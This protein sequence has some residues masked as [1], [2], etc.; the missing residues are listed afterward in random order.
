[1]NISYALLESTIRF[2][3]ICY[4]IVEIFPNGCNSTHGSIKY[5]VCVCA[6]SV[7]NHHA[8][9]LLFIIISCFRV[10]LY[11]IFSLYLT[12]DVIS[13]KEVIALQLRFSISS[14]NSFEKILSEKDSSDKS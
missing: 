7:Y 5:C 3:N 9:L 2:K 10:R 1:M 13:R 12:N 6:S 14:K 4:L 8:K 11:H